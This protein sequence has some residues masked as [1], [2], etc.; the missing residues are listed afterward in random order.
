MTDL[1][2]NLELTA[3][4]GLRVTTDV[5]GAVSVQW[6]SPRAGGWTSHD[7]DETAALKEF[8][9]AHSKEADPA[10][11]PGEGPWQLHPV[12]GSTTVNVYYDSPTENLLQHMEVPVSALPALGELLRSLP[13]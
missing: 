7:P 3:S 12:E 11:A 6:G 9:R 10:P 5:R 4:N 8:F 1:P 13:R 2:P